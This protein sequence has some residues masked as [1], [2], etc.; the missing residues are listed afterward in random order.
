MALTIKYCGLKTPAD[1]DL[2]VALGVD[3]VGFMQFPKS[4]RA[5]PLADIGALVEATRDRAESCVLLVN[6]DDALVAEVAALRPDWL[7]LHGDETPARV[8]EIRDQSGLKVMKAIKVGEAADLE[9]MPDYATV[10]DRLLLDAKPPKGADRP[11][12]HGNV[13]DWGLLE[14]VDPD[15]DFMLAGGLSL[16]NVGEAI[17]MVRP[18]GLDLS[19]ALEREKGIKD[20]ELMRAF[21]AAVRSAEAAL[22]PTDARKAEAL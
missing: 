19:S 17:E 7:Q 4:P 10:A 13:F 9:P 3:M 18:F 12:G 20:H 8:T 22:E 1:L 6:P 21:M 5:L 14:N 2:A 15:L 11:G 16:T